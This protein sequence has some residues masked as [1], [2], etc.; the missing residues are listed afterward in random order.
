MP[1][2]PLV[3]PL[4]ELDPPEV[5]P[6]LV[7][8]EPPEE[9]PPELPELLLPEPELEPELDGLLDELPPDEPPLFPL[10]AYE[11]LGADEFDEA[12]VGPFGTLLPP[13]LVMGGVEVACEARSAA[14]CA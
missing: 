10:P 12:F 11:L 14:I 8:N 6:L 9:L 4:P 13:P 1:E 2:L 3:L 5:L 7:A